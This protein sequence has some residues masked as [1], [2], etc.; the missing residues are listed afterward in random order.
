MLSSA[1]LPILVPEF[2]SIESMFK[3]TPATEGAARFIYMEASN[4]SRDLQNERVLAKALEASAG[5]YLKFG[6]IDVD[7][8]SLLGKP[9]PKKGYPGI[10][11]P[12]QYEIGRPVQVRVDG[13]RTFVKAQL[14]EGASPS[15]AQA[16]LVWESLTTLNP[17]ARWY[18]S[19][20]GVP[21]QTDVE[22]D[23]SS[24]DK[25]AVIKAV[26]WTNI[27]LSRTP[28]NPDL[29]TAQAVP[30]GV[31]AKALTAGGNL[32]VKALTAGYGTDSAG[33]DGGAA[34]RKQS[35]D[36]TQH[37]YFDFRERVSKAIREKAITNPGA[38]SIMAWCRQEFG[39]S[40]DEAA[41]YVERFMRDLSRAKRSMK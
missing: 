10:P 24:G 36:G 29:P 21:T 23:P 38:A 35:L 14:Y 33:L 26:R 3:A 40:Q 39:A 31:L 6:N 11:N 5:Y 41:E 30:F 25:L 7:H 1:S 4:E 37:N 2:L 18:P 16:N 34:L 22:I 12:E 15:A 32:L 8:L 27:G 9:N 19:V 17:P 20:G 13:A 28:V